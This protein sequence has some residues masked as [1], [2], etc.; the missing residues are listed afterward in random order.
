M[1][2]YTPKLRLDRPATLGHCEN[3]AHD[4]PGF[5]SLGNAAIGYDGCVVGPVVQ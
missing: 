1:K 5:C 3:G 2:Y 4:R